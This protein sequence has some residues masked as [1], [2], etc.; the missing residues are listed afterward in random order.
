MPK[1]NDTELVVLAAAAK[2]DNGSILPLPKRL[3]LAEDA[4]TR[5]LG[6]LVKKKLAAELPATRD[7]AVWRDSKD[8][9]PIMLA[10]TKAGLRAIGIEPSGDGKAGE[11][12]DKKSQQRPAKEP[13]LTQSR[14]RSRAHKEQGKRDSPS[15][16][17]R[18]DTK[19]AQIINLLR[20][21]KGASI[22]QMMEATG[23]QAH[24]VRGVMSGTLKKKLGL[25]IASEKTEN[26][27]RIYR[28][29]DRD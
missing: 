19:Q 29:V 27:G 14:K 8:G 11:V 3:K 22:E 2:R 15:T 26:R 5:V 13:T 10:G 7:T 6:S 1:L 4:T 25:G 9:E 12:T 21:S 24:S 16:E 28:I 17:T 18:A 23:W 20:R